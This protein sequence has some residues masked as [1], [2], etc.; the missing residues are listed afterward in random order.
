MYTLTYILAAMMDL[1]HFYPARMTSYPGKTPA[2]PAAL[3]RRGAESSGG[4]LQ[5][6][7][8]HGVVALICKAGF[9]K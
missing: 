9:Q 5:W 2:P 1:A 8:A 6:R 7:G 3:A 4:L